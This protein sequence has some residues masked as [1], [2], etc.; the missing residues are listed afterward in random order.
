M[1]NVY[2]QVGD[3]MTVKQF[4]ISAE[5]QTDNMIENQIGAKKEAIRR[6]FA[7]LSETNMKQLFNIIDDCRTSNATKLVSKSEEYVWDKKLFIKIYD[8]V[9]NCSLKSL[10]VY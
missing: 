7:S 8:M 5:I 10:I 6:K 3:A 4:L 9:L 2:Y 1:V